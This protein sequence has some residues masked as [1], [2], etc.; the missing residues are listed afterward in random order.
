MCIWDSRQRWVC[1]CVC[2]CAYIE[3]VALYLTTLIAHVR[4]NA[5]PAPLA[6]S[7]LRGAPGAAT[8][9]VCSSVCSTVHRRF[10]A[11]SLLPCRLRV[12]HAAG[13]MA[14]R[15]QEAAAVRQ[16]HIFQAPVGCSSTRRSSH[17]HHCGAPYPCSA[18]CVAASRVLRSFVQ[19]PVCGNA[20]ASWDARPSHRTAR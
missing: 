11:A 1:V 20:E 15:A 14:R 3:A 13:E 12:G 18:L 10:V 2:V 7:A 8:H 4:C 19:C 17:W 16:L 6:S 5:Q 9:V